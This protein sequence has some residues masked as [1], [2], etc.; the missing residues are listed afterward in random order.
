MQKTLAA[1]GVTP[2]VMAQVIQFQK[3]LMA[4]GISPAEIAELFNRAVKDQL[5]EKE[6]ADLVAAMMAKKGCSKEEIEKMLQLQRS[7]NGG[8]LAPGE[9]LGSG[10]SDLQSLGAVD[11]SLLQKA[12]LMQK[13]LAS[14]GLS[15]E[16][17]GKA[18]LLQNAMIEAGASPENVANCM[19][20]TLVE[21]GL[22]LEHMIALLE[23]ELKAALAKGLTAS[24]IVGVLHFDKI[25]GASSTARRIMR[26][27]N[28]EALRL[29]EATVKKQVPGQKNSIMEAM[30]SSLGAVMDTATLQAMEVSQAMAAAGA[31]KEEIEEMMQMI[32]NKGGGIS[33]EFLASIKQAMEEGGG[34]P[35]AKLAALKNAMEDEMNSMTNALR[36]TFINRIPTAEDIANTCRYC[37]NKLGN[38]LKEVSR[39]IFKTH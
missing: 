22:S 12:L 30:K 27:I 5:G 9:K 11:A 29:M 38:P 36:N 25:L 6:V 13:V 15:P 1:S 32:I 33:E 23:I 21:S 4:A 28:P 34:D 19:H 39:P 37:K 14:C 7:L 26:R 31:S 17:L 10:L 8:V 24:D 35:R 2:E 18:F 16:D 3:A 20:R